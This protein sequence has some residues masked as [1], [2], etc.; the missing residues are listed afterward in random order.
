MQLNRVIPILA[1]LLVA[2]SAD[3]IPYETFIDVDDEGDLQDLLAANDITQDTFDELLDLLDSGVDLNT[4]DRAEL[5]ALPNLTYVDVDAIIAFRE[6]QHG[7]IKDPTDLVGAGALSQEKLLGIAAFLTLREPGANPLAAH[8]F[9]HAMTRL[10]YHDTKLG[11]DL[12]VPPIA[13][14][15]R[16]TAMRYL[17]AGIVVATT[18]LDIGDPVYDPN[19]NALIADPRGLQVHAPK[20]YVKWED[21]DKTGIVGTF[22]AGFAQRLIFDNSQHY[23]PNGVYLDDQ[24]YYTSDLSSECKQSGGEFVTSPCTGPAGNEYV[25]PDWIWR[26]GLFGVAGGLKHIELSTGWLQAYAW[27]SASRRSI[28]Q[29]ELVDRGKCADPHDDKDPNCGAPSVFVRPQGDLLTPTTRFSFE[30]L[31][32]VFGERLAGANV[33]YFA[34][35]RNSV[36]LTGYGAVEQNLVGGI[37]LDFQEWSRL[38]TGKKFGAIGANMSIGRDWLDVFGEAGVSFDAM[39]PDRTLTKAKGGGGPAAVIRITA[40]K[41][42]Q[43]LEIVGRYYSTDY[44]NPYARPI[45]QPDEFEGQRARDEAGGRIRYVGS[46]KNFQLRSLVDVWVSPST[47]TPKLD[48]YVR[49]NVRTSDQ[50][51]LGLWERYQDKDLTQGGHDQCFEVSTATNENGEPIPCGGQQLTSIVRAHYI[52]D[53][54][55]AATLMLEHQLL[56]D[57]TKMQYKTSFRQDIAAWLIALYKPSRDLRVRAR[58][59]YLDTAIQDDTYLERSLSALVDAAIRVRTGDVLRVRVDSKFWL[60]QRASTLARLPNPEFT[61]WLAYEAKL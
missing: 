27:A 31:P 57:N 28:Y 56:D 35:R 42:R 16:V 20:A 30:T 22:R 9:V 13:L 12:D 40:T 18:R 23:T 50:L 61:A 21:K 32:N 25:T 14:R 37:D 55:F 11:G 7:R 33:A 58:V 46:T 45:S 1:V 17:T 19:R 36:G 10:S 4:A 2:R 3:A 39:Q 29:Y 51:W 60:D 52:P 41:K 59:R 8:G 48:T 34:D 49:A 44:L 43:E 47:N 53:P 54:S 15:G 6:L 24:I 38:P 5:Y 26:D